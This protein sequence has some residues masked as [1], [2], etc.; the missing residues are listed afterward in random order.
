M[1]RDR[2]GGY[3]SSLTDAQQGAGAVFCDQKGRVIQ[4]VV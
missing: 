2:P 1:R 3:H 4:V